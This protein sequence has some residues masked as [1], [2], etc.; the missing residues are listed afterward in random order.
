MQ[1]TLQLNIGLFCRNTGLFRGNIGLDCRNMG[2][3]CGNIEIFRCNIGL[4]GGTPYDGFLFSN[5]AALLVE[6]W[7]EFKAPLP[8]Y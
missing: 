6:F 3:L 2:F 4:F 8:E 7:R 1:L 5:A